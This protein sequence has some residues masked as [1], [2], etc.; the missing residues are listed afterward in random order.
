MGITA[1]I[2][3]GNGGISLSIHTYQ[4]LSEEF[5]DDIEQVT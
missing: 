4:K 2:G 3:A 1:G 5:F